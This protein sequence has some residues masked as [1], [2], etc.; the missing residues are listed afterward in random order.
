VSRQER[1]RFWLDDLM[2]WAFWSLTREVTQWQQPH[3]KRRQQAQPAEQA[4]GALHLSVLA[5]TSRFEALVIVLP[6]KACALP[7]N[8]LP[9]LLAG[10]RDQ[11]GEPDPF[12]RLFAFGGSFFPHSNDPEGQARKFIETRIMARWQQFK[13]R[14]R[15]IERGG[16]GLVLLPS[17]KIKR[18]Q[19]LAGLRADLLKE[20]AW[21]SS[22]SVEHAD[23]ASH[24][25]QSG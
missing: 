21:T 5:A 25:P 10:R 17:R 7:L 13:L 24:A 4:L 11:R 16:P 3:G 9:S 23:L 18:A 14:P 19:I 22:A 2:G 8:S 20:M 6:P 12:E 15:Q 1:K